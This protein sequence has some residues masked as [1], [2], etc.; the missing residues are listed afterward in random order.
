MLFNLPIP[1]TC[2]Y[3]SFVFN[4]NP[5]EEEYYDLGG[6]RE[7]Y[8]MFLQKKLLTIVGLTF[9]ME[10][11]FTGIYIDLDSFKNY[12]EGKYGTTT[13]VPI[14]VPDTYKQIELI[15]CTDLQSKSGRQFLQ[16]IDRP[17][18]KNVWIGDDKISVLMRKSLWKLRIPTNKTEKINLQTLSYISSN[19]EKIKGKLNE[20]A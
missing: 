9:S 11:H 20:L 13:S 18:A 2:L 4:F 6:I 1:T 10:T 5:T 16:H 3:A 19:V 8:P 7:L 17:N 12:Y 15:Y 14:D